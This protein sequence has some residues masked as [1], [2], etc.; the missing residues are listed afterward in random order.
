MKTIR[1]KGKS[2]DFRQGGDG[3]DYDCSVPGNN[4]GRHSHSRMDS[5]TSS[6]TDGSGT[7][8][9]LE[10]DDN[11]CLSPSASKIFE[12]TKEK[13]WSTFTTTAANCPSILYGGNKAVQRYPDR[14]IGS[15]NGHAGS[16]S[17]E[18]VPVK[19]SWKEQATR[20]ILQRDDDGYDEASASSEDEQTARTL[21]TPS[22]FSSAYATSRPGT[23]VN[24][25]SAPI[26][27]MQGQSRINLL[28]GGCNQ[29]HF[30]AASP[31]EKGDISHFGPDSDSNLQSPLTRTDDMF[32]L[33]MVLPPQINNSQSYAESQRK[34]AAKQVGIA[35]EAE[36]RIVAP[37]VS[38][39]TPGSCIEI[40]L[41]S[42]DVCVA[43]LCSVDVLKMR[44]VFFHDILEEQDQMN[45][46]GYS[47][48]SS[49]MANNNKAL[50]TGS[51]KD[52]WR[53]A[54]IV[55]ESSPFEAAAFVS[56]LF[57]NARFH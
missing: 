28:T 57:Y 3:L 53:S 42:E 52:I 7:R 12:K 19:L 49:S 29:N 13:I 39:L 43:V 27:T 11:V 25:I 37:N 50:C 54:I 48:T 56:F 36:S 34:Q 26:R 15:S 9:D 32:T 10:I 14:R 46:S 23:K 20:E 30:N 40:R 35:V 16:S 17:G 4:H 51:T 5:F 2:T 31:T 6:I 55:P 44:S 18:K 45:G 22:E 8:T 33:G 38:R 1:S 24:N 47:S 21:V 41:Q